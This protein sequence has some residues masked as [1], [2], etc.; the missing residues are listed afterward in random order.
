MTLLFEITIPFTNPVLIFTLVLLIILFAPILF[1]KIKIPGII[2]LILAGVAVGPHGLKLLAEN[3]SI[4]LLGPIGLLYLMFLTGLE[5]D[6]RDFSKN[7]NSSLLF[8]SLTFIIPIAFGLLISIFIL[9]LDFIAALLL[10]SMFSTNT[11]ISYPIAGRLGI[12][13]NRAVQN[14]IGGTI[15]TDT[16]VLLL[17]AVILELNSGELNFEFWLKLLISLGIFVFAV[18]WVLPKLSRCTSCSIY[19]R[20]IFNGCECRAY[21]WCFSCRTCVKQTHPPFFSFNEPYYFYRKYP[22]YSLFSS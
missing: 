2:G 11:L 14:A 15:I 5:I 17:L 9:Q 13:K 6:I 19:F 1:R 10:A 21:Y 18:T 7:K 16:A 22:F 12:I 20:I 8:G 3:S 4:D